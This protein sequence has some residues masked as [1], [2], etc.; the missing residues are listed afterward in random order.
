MQ[1]SIERIVIVGAGNLATNLGE[2]LIRK[3][4]KV[5]QVFSRTAESAAAL[6]ERYGNEPDLIA[7][8]YPL[9]TF[10]I[11][12]KARKPLYLIIGNL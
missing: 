9:H 5:E 6:A 7:L 4:R 11:I 10:R 3:C 8:K 2:A 1:A 12:L